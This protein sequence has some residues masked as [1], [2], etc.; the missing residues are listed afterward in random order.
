MKVLITGITGMI[1]S[2]FAAYLRKAGH[3]VFGIARASV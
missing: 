2:T 1:G 3:Q